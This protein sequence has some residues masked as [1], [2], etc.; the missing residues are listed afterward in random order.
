MA[1]VGLMQPATAIREAREDAERAIELNS[2]AAA[3]YLALAWVQINRDWNWEGAELSLNKAAELEPGSAA[4]LRHRSFLYQAVGRLKEAIDFHQ[5]AVAL[6]PLFAGSYSYLAF[7]LYSAGEYEKSEAALQKALDLNPQKTYDH[8]TRGE[9]LLAQGHVQQ[10]LAE[11]EREP[12]VIWRLTGEA[13]AYH[14]LGRG[15]DSN[16]ALKQLIKDHQQYMAYQVAEI[17]AY[18]GDANRAFEWLNRAYQQR[19][20]GLRSLKID[21]LIK[22][23]RTD[24]RYANLL[25]QMHLPD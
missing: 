12:A 7:L 6:D 22:G 10:A 25:R 2:N 18:R 24:P 4:I 5:Q 16:A 9:I 15:E 13:L 11:M 23:L 3:G 19:D 14:S 20:S 21:P 17:Y 8:F 1:D